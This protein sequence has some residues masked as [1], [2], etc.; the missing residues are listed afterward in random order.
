MIIFI[1]GSPSKPPVAEHTIFVAPGAH[2]HGRADLPA[3]WFDTTQ[4]DAGGEPLPK[5]FPVKFF[6]GQAEVPDNIG[7]YMI[8]H[9]LAEKSRLILPNAWDR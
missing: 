8:T 2:L 9:G 1:H 5:T 7:K 6:H 3:D 4:K